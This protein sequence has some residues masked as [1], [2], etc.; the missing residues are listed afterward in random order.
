MGSGKST[1]GK[2]LQTQLVSQ[3]DPSVQLV[4]LDDEIVRQAGKSIPQIFA[5]S[6]EQV[7]RDLECVCLARCLEKSGSQII[8]TGGGAILS[9]DN[10]ALMQQKSTVIWLH[11]SPEILAQRIAGDRNRPLLDGED[12]LQKIRALSVVRN[13]LYAEI[14]DLRVDTGLLSDQEAISSILEFMAE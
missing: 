4:D 11:A 9:A 14:A 10:R 13:P 6:G 1:L 7:F 12:A 3:A 5:D 2:L 8:A